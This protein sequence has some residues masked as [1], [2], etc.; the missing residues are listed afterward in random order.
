MNHFGY[1]DGELWC[2]DVPLARIAAEV[3]TP[4]YVYSSAT[5]TRHYKVFDD[6]LA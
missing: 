2:E 1:R 6:A 3:G 5:I 4:T